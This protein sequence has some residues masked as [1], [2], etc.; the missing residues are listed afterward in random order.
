[1]DPPETRGPYIKC[2]VSIT[3]KIKTE[4]GRN[5]LVPDLSMG[6]ADNKSNK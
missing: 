4:A 3:H 1:M 6:L 5:I 2:Q